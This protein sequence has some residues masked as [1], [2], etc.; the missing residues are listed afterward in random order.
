MKK[1][2]KTCG[3]PTVV[4]SP[5]ILRSIEWNRSFVVLFVFGS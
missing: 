3:S 1:G 5:S 2:E 4:S